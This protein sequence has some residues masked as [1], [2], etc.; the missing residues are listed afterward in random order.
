MNVL[1]RYIVKEIL[2]GSF[3]ALILLLTLFNLFTLTDELKNLGKGSYNLSDIF[4]YL[5]LTSPRVCYELVPSSA[6]LGSLF[7]LGS[8]GNNRELVAMRAAG[9]SILGIVKSTLVAGII[10]AIFAFCIS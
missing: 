1:T 3:I 9:V 2:K 4:T 10:L 5:A 7:V 8:M 6:L